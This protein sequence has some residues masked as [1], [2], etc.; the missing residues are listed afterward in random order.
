MKKGITINNYMN[1][2]LS[3]IKFA[4]PS[5]GSHVLFTSFAPPSMAPLTARF[6]IFIYPDSWP[7]YL[8]S[9]GITRK[10][11]PLLSATWMGTRNLK[12]I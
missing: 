2:F 10:C 8:A 4:A 5:R 11:L 6:W 1:A 3:K 7:K 9:G 12:N